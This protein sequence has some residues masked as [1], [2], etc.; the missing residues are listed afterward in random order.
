MPGASRGGP[1]E[2]PVPF[3][4]TRKHEGHPPLDVAGRHN[5]STLGAEKEGSARDR[6]S[7]RCSV[8][9]LCAQVTME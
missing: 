6:P 7:A 4:P 8:G 9:V 2:L 1:R 5:W 3:M